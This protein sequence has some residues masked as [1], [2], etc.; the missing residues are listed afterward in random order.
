MRKLSKTNIA[1]LAFGFTF[2]YVPIFFLI[3]FAFSDSEIEGVWTKFSMRWFVA[4]FEDDDLI[5][6]AITSFE[7][8]VISATGA[9]ILGLIAAVATTR[10]GNFIGRSFLSRAVTVPIVMPEIITGFSLLMLFLTIEKVTGISFDKGIVTVTI[11]HVMASMAYVHMTI[12][13][14]LANF[15][16]SLEE[17]ALNLGANPFKVF[18]YITVPLIAKSIFAGWLL[19]FTLSLDDLVIAS[20]LSGPGATTLPML[21]FS[22]VKIGVTPAINAFSTMFICIVA[23]CL[24]LAYVISNKEKRTTAV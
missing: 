1:F 17:A 20:F 9:T 4:V 22:N 10:P 7:I 18:I 16:Q 19:A 2:L 11:G 13:A 15:D 8:A 21:I 24:V 6:A 14:R 23:V 5:N 3:G 12:R